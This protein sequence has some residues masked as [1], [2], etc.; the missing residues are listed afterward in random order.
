MFKK[1]VWK[2][3]TRQVVFAAIGA[4]LYAVLSIATNFLNLPG[5]GNVSLR[6]AVAIPMFFGVAF[7]PI[8]GFISGFIGNIL[9]DLVSG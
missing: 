4:A 7:G 3:G 1:E 2:F 8:V 9:S 6:P 5:A